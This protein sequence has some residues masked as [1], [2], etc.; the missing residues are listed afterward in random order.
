MFTVK[1]R[2]SEYDAAVITDEKDLVDY[3]YEVIQYIH[4][5]KQVNCFHFIPIFRRLVIIFIILVKYNRQNIS[6]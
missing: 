5:S 3:F 2:K 4:N 1:T 6:I